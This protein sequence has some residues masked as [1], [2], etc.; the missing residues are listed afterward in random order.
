MSK[1]TA[2]ALPRM[3]LVVTAIAFG[4]MSAVALAQDTSSSVTGRVLDAEGAP[5]AGAVV[6]ILHTPS[7]TRKLVTTD[8]NG[9]YSSKG[10]RVGGGFVVSVT[11]D[12]ME[13]TKKDDVELR[14]GEVGTV[15]LIMGGDADTLGEVVVTAARISDVFDSNKMGAGSNVTREQIEALPSISRSIED[16]VRTDPR[17]VQVDKERGGIS[18]AGQN[19]RYNN[20][21]IDGVSSNDEFGLNDNGFPALN[22]P[23]SLDAIEELNINVASYDVTQS[24]FTGANI[25]AVTKSGTNEFHG[26]VYGYYRNKDWTGDNPEGQSFTGFDSET[27]LGMTLGGPIIKD[28]LFF[29]VSYEKFKGKSPAPVTNQRLRNGTLGPVVSA[30]TLAAIT[31]RATVLGFNTGSFGINGIDN[32]DEKVIAK[33]DWNINDQHRAAFRYG[34]TEGSI[35]RTPGVPG[36][37]TNQAGVSFADY[38]YLDNRLNKNLT[39]Q[40]Y[41]DWSDV[42][43][44]EV[45]LSRNTYESIPGNSSTAP[46]VNISVPGAVPGT[47]NV[48]VTFGTERSRQAN[49]L[50]TT[51]SVGFFKGNLF[52]GDHTVSFGADYKR[53]EVYNLFL[54][55]AYGTYNYNS[56]ADFQSGRIGQY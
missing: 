19:N 5:V 37:R 12:G 30:E 6:E 54:Q 55:D 47:G 39:A 52:L 17:L 48:T 36:L 46:E 56:L 51:T 20:I 11:K 9:R 34:R 27:T 16:Y 28:R 40:L 3:R 1:N 33:I 53:N 49:V 21:T 50:D 45:S 38:W 22:Q 24:D 23:I 13:A 32:D 31:A 8:E 10:L 7:G 25:N 43:S 42:F 41:S 18:A 14:L 35:L 26:S 29:F 4:L 44:T 2:S 15:N